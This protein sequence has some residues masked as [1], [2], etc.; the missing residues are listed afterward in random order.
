MENLKNLWLK[1][2]ENGIPFPILQDLISKKP[3]ITYTTFVTAFLIYVAS[4]FPKL[5]KLTGGISQAGASELFLIASGL[6]LGRSITRKNVDKSNT[7]VE[8]E[9]PKS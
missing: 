3:S 1:L 6:Y 8:K 4:L 5:Q 9:K 7:K 2:S